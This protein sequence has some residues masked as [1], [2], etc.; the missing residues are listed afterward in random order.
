MTEIYIIER[1]DKIIPQAGV[2]CFPIF[3]GMVWIF[4]KLCSSHFPWFIT[5]Q[6]LMCLSKVSNCGHTAL[7]FVFNV[8]FYVHF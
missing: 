6:V 3:Q 2:V 8:L 7:F 5:E 4:G 1:G